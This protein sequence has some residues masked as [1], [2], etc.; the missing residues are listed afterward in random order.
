MTTAR[1][2]LLLAVLALPGCA[3]V[4]FGTAGG[5]AGSEIAEDDGVFD[6]FERTEA[7]AVVRDALD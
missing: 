6:P 4:L 5:I 3:A 1:L 2:L 7:G